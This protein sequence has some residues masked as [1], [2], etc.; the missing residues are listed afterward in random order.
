M[1][2]ANVN[3]SQP[4]E[5]KRWGALSVLLLGTFMVILDSFIVNVAIPSIQSQL[6]ASSS[7][8]Q[9]IVAAYVLSYAVLLIPGARIGDWIG[10]KKSFILGMILFVAASALCGFAT[11]APFLIF[12][13]VIQGIGAAI[14]IPQ[15]LS[16]IHVIF[17]PEEKGKAIGLYGAVS[18]LGLIAGQ[19]VGGMLLHFDAL[20]LGWRSV[21]LINI[22]IGL[23]AVLLIIPL[24]QENRSSDK[25]NFDVWGIVLLTCSLLPCIYPMVVG[26]EAGWPLWVYASFLGGIAFL[27][28]FVWHEKKLLRNGKSPLIPVAIF[29]ERSFTV[30]VLALIAFQLENSGFFLTVSITLLDGLM[31]SPMQSA[32]AFMPIGIAFFAASLLAPKW[33]NR[34]GTA[35][36]KWGAWR[37]AAGYAA[38]IWFINAGGAALDWLPLLIPFLLIGWGQ[39]LVASPLMKT[40]LSGIPSQ[41]AGSASG[42]LTTCMQTANVLGVAVIGTIFFSFLS[43]HDTEPYM[44]AFV[45]ALVCSIALSIVTFLFILGLQNRQK[46]AA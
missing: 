6:Q 43:G 39:G 46:A 36:L 22:P 21:F 14:L 7:Q 16:I 34:T 13:R 31:L 9:F 35:V 44:H 24:V 1:I 18:G 41:Y 20:G 42:V 26:R 8:I 3:A 45:I 38:V 15:V 10:R 2:Q 23:L 17:P 33:L 12:S 19:I 40:I 5:A 4:L 30:G 37:M 11:G 27:L 32:A 25:K 29:Q 28:A